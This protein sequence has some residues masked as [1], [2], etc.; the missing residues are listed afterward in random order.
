MFLFLFIQFVLIVNAQQ[1]CGIDCIYSI[2]DEKLTIEVNGMIEL[3]SYD[4]MDSIKTIEKNEALNIKLKNI[5]KK[6]NDL[7]SFYS[8]CIDC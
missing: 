5:E 6:E 4:E 7:I 2:T 1:S 8:I 3:E